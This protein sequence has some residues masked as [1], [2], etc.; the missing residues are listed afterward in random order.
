MKLETTLYWSDV[1]WLEGRDGTPIANMIWDC[2]FPSLQLLNNPL[3]QFYLP[4]RSK[5]LKCGGS[6]ALTI[7]IT[8]K[9]VFCPFWPRKTYSFLLAHQP[10]YHYHSSFYSSSR[11]LNPS[12]PP[13]LEIKGQNSKLTWQICPSIR[14]QADVSAHRWGGTNTGIWTAFGGIQMFWIITA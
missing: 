8:I 2:V 6:K 9:R 7:H 13:H 3:F 5:G 1:G 14:L 12:L 4:S 10:N 11:W